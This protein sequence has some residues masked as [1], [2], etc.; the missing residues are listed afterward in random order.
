MNLRKA[1]RVA[2]A[3]TTTGFMVGLALHA[4]GGD[5]GHEGDHGHD[6]RVRPESELDEVYAGDGFDICLFSAADEL[7]D[8][9]Y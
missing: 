5:H 8:C 6:E 4:H 7:R 1:S 9:E 3:T 2:L